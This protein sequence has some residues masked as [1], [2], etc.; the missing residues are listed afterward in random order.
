MKHTFK[1]TLAAFISMLASSASAEDYTVSR[2]ID[3][4]VSTQQAWNVVGDFCDIDDWHP[5][6][7]SCSLKVIDGSL[8]RILNTTSGAEFVEKR[9]A[10]EP[11]LS[12]TYSIVSSP[13]PVENYI[14]TLSVETLKST[15]ITWEGRFKSDDPSMEDTIAGIYESGLAAVEEQF[16]E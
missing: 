8:H 7:S 6:V 2:L 16:A 13:L 12:Y 11:G 15:T 3:L 5:A 14:A 10:V 1:I 9:I 4:D